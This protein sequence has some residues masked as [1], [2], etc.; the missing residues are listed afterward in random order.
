MLAHNLCKGEDKMIKIKRWF[1]SKGGKNVIIVVLGLALAISIV[2]QLVGWSNIGRLISGTIGTYEEGYYCMPTCTETDGRFLVMPGE[3]VASFGGA[4]IVLWIE[5]PPGSASFD[6]GIFDGDSGRDS[7]GNINMSGGNWDDTETN[8]TYTLYA[9]PVRDGTGMTVVGQWQGNDSNPTADPTNGWWTASSETMPNNAWYDITVKNMAAAQNPNGNY[10]YRFEAT[11]PV[12]GGGANAFKLRSHGSLTSGRAELVDANFALVG[13]LATQQDLPIIYPDWTGDYNNPGPTTTYDGNWE[14]YFEVPAGTKT[15]S[16]WDGDFDRGTASNP[17]E[18]GDTDDPNTAGIPTWAVPDFTV[19]EGAGGKGA[20]ADDS[21]W[22]V[23]RREPPVFYSLIGP[24]G[25]TVFVN[26]EPSGTEEWEEFVVSSDPD[27]PDEAVD[28]R[29]DKVP[30]GTYTLKIEGLDLHNFVWFRI[31]YV[32]GKEECPECPVCPEPDPTQECAVYPTDTPEPQPEPTETPIPPE[33]TTCP[34][35]QPVDLVYILDVSGSMDQMYPGSGKK[36]DAAKDAI[37]ELNDLVKTEGGSGSRVALVT[38][39][40]AG[41]GQGRPPLYPTDIQVVSDFTTDIDGFNNKVKSL[42]ASGGTPTAEALQKVA[43]WLPGAWDP[44]HLPVVILLSDGVPTVDLETYGFQ[45]YDVQ[46]IDIYN[47]DGTARSV[48]G[49]RTSGKY[50][51]QYG[52]KS[53][54][55]LA[56]TMA[57]VQNLKSAISDVAVH[58]I[59]IQGTGDGGIFN[60]QILKYVAAQTGGEFYMAEDTDSLKDSLK[61]A[62]FNSACGEAEPPGDTGAGGGGGGAGCDSPR[63]NQ[64]NVENTTNRPFYGIRYEFRGGT[65][66]KSGDWDEYAFTVTKAQAEAMSSVKIDAKAGRG[67]GSAT[68]TGCNFAGTATCGPVSDSYFT[69]SF[70]GAKDNGDG[71]MTLTFRVQNDRRAA[72]SNVLIGLPSGVKPS[73][74]TSS[75]QSEVC[76]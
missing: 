56:D 48:E 24:D 23:Y 39:H 74:P 62:Y 53:G 42:T 5:A 41:K 35:P 75:Y 6:V 43:G 31:D 20:P 45:D 2:G 50:Y 72:I 4:R 3:S 29:V 64:Y 21:A 73:W 57:E 63:I 32:I 12:E 60:A 16:L 70:Q 28:L 44:N 37:Y 58:T 33:P 18:G 15:L 13:M 14:F 66:V 51:S 49:V 52:Q 1:A 61:R 46:V 17:V 34:D 11:R 54:E 19:P 76:P 9:D 8:T 25:T 65:E 68:L 22:G 36:L 40:S 47:S 67:E 26:D 7:E 71:T 38:F 30:A 10:Y 27:L 59:A 69:F 55:P